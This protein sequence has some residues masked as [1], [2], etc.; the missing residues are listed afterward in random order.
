M[1]KKQEDVS[2]QEGNNKNSIKSNFDNI[3][4]LESLTSSKDNGKFYLILLLSY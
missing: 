2:L 4:S 1:P 3:I